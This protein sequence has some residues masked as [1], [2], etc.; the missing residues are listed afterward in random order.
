MLRSAA[1]GVV[2]NLH[3]ASKHTGIIHT[4]EVGGGR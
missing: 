4:K 1:D 2:D 3:K